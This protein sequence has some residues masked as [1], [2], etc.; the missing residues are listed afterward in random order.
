MSVIHLYPLPRHFKSIFQFIKMLLL[1][2]PPRRETRQFLRF[3]PLKPQFITD[4]Y[5]AKPQRLSPIRNGV[6]VAEVAL[7]EVQSH[8]FCIL[9]FQIGFQVP[10]QQQTNPISNFPPRDKECFSA[11]TLAFSVPPMWLLRE[12][13]CNQDF[14]G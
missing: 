1:L 3:S 8:A 7:A 14:H 6:L 9:I 13:L 10:Q 5:A 12:W 4:L 2:L 11:I